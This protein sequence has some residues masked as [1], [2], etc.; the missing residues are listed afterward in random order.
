MS[1]CN[2]VQSLASLWHR[3]NRVW[4][5][6]WWAE[7]TYLLFSWNLREFGWWICATSLPCE[8]RFFYQKKMSKRI[9]PLSIIQ[10]ERTQQ[11]DSVN[12]ICLIRSFRVFCH[13]CARCAFLVMYWE[14]FIPVTAHWHAENKTC[15]VSARSN[16]AVVVCLSSWISSPRGKFWRSKALRVYIIQRCVLFT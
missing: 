9:Q 4:P 14:L 5:V 15:P 11:I 12:S 1:F 7:K 13:Y 16:V 3:S 8:L 2:V 10:K 6:D